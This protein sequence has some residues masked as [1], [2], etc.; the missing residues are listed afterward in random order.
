VEQVLDLADALDPPR[1]RAECLDQVLV[2]DLP[3]QEDDQSGETRS[4]F[5]DDRDRAVY[6]DNSF[7]AEN[8]MPGHDRVAVGRFAQVA[9]LLDR[10][11]HGASAFAVETLAEEGDGTRFV[12]SIADRC[13]QAF[14]GPSK[15]VLT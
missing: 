9:K 8:R 7:S 2:F 10:E 12:D 6:V 11:L 3:A 4:G 5:F 14:V 15:N 1:R 13:E